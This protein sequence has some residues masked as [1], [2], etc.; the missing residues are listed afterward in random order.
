MKQATSQNSTSLLTRILV[1][2]IL[3][4]GIFSTLKLTE[5]HHTTHVEIVNLETNKDTFSVSYCPPPLEMDS[6]QY[7]K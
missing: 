3:A 6:A 5:K 4:V 1:M 2:S 7:I